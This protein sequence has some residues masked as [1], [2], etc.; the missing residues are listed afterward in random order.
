M[1]DREYASKNLDV[2]TIW[3]IPNELVLLKVSNGQKSVLK[4]IMV[5]NCFDSGLWPEGLG[6]RMPTIKIKVLLLHHVYYAFM[7]FWMLLLSFWLVMIMFLALS[8]FLLIQGNYSVPINVRRNL[9]MTSTNSG[10][11]LTFS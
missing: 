8:L 11:D 3:S 10:S 9:S 7:F 4:V 2:I 1:S 6:D 5:N